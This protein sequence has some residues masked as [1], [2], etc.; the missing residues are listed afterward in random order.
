MS[1]T[2]SNSGSES[3]LTFQ[4]KIN[5]FPEVLKMHL[6]DY[7]LIDPKYY[8]DIQPG[9]TIRYITHEGKFRFG[10]KVLVNGYPDFLVLN[11]HKFTTK[12]SIDLNTNIIFLKDHDKVKKE[13]VMK[14]NL[15]QLY[16]EGYVEIHEE[17]SEDLKPDLK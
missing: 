9:A 4:E 17:P 14:E 13:S 1:D 3:G 6:E 16:K 12:W 2:E 11:N 8:K 10:G 5:A 7:V 15:F